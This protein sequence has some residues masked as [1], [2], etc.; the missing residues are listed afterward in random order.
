M[1]LFSTRVRPENT[2]FCEENTNIYGCDD[3]YEYPEGYLWNGCK[4]NL[5][6]KIFENTMPDRENQIMKMLK[7][8]L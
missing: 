2:L 4:E 6:S 7:Q 5:D 1:E 8:M 3:K